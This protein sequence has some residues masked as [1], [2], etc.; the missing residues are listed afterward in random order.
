MTRAQASKPC[1]GRIKHPLSEALLTA[2]SQSHFTDGETEAEGSNDLARVTWPLSGS[3][4]HSDPSLA[5]HRAP[6]LPHK[7]SGLDPIP[8]ARGLSWPSLLCQLPILAPHWS[9]SL[10]LP[11]SIQR[12]CKPTSPQLHKTSKLP[13]WA[14][15]VPS[16]KSCPPPPSRCPPPTSA[17]TGFFHLVHP[18]FKNH[19]LQEATLITPVQLSQCLCHLVPEANPSVLGTCWPDASEVARV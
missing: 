15:F 14:L 12:S 13:Y 4:L 18:F 2:V 7:W 9:P 19:H 16:Q 17:H 8:G 6:H 3:W 10:F 1:L 11:Q 5:R